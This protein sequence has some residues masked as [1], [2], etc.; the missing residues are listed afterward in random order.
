F[1]DAIK[2]IDALVA[3]KPGYAKAYFQRGRAYQGLKDYL[4]AEKDYQKAIELDSKN[5]LAYYNFG[6][7]KFLQQDYEAAIEQFSKVIEINPKDA[8]AFNDR[9]SCY[10]MLEK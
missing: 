6:T 8:Y 1:N 5:A 7:L 2:T 3:K 10:R 4:N 9:G